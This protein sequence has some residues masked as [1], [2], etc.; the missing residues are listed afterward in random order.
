MVGRQWRSFA[1]LLAFEGAAVAVILG[2]VLHAHRSTHFDNV[3]LR[4]LYLHLTG[5]WPHALLTLSDPIVSV[6]LLAVVLVAA[7]SAR[8]YTLAVLAVTG[9]VLTVSLTQFVFKPLVARPYGEHTPT[10]TS[11]AYPS[12][13][14][15][16]VASTATV[17]VV[18]ICL[19]PWPIV[20]RL[21]AIAVTVAWTVFAGIGL[22]INFYHY[23][24]DVIGAISF[25]LAV[26]LTLAFGLDLS[27]LVV[28][29]RTR[30]PRE[31]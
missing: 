16:L 18:A 13:H 23:T 14:E 8:R 29:A 5:R 30:T 21:A 7:T 6:A 9:P 26:V 19:L 28:R 4:D 12:G 1:A 10:G 15:S 3:I 25:S 22:V 27:S 17:V 31:A 11:L 20:T 2:I 24:T